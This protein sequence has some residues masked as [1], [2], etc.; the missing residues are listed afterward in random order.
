MP[1]RKMKN[2][3][4]WRQQQDHMLWT[5]L[6]SGSNRHGQARGK[7][8]DSPFYRRLLLV[9]DCLITP[10]R[11]EGVHHGQY[12]E[13]ESAYIT[14]GEWQVFKEN[15]MVFNTGIGARMDLSGKYSYPGN[16]C[17]GVRSVALTS[18]CTLNPR[19]MGGWNHPSDDILLSSRIPTG[20]NTTWTISVVPPST[21]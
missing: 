19:L 12:S 13:V 10:P 21:F 11:K 20:R 5:C 17:L 14:L 9:D 7:R 2:R 4:I 18:F 3:P 6:S 8:C 1:L 15:A 16:G